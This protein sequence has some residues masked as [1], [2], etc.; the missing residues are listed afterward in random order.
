MSSRGFNTP[1]VVLTQMREYVSR[2]GRPYF[3]GYM[4][5]TKLV[6]LHDPD[7]EITGHEVRRWNLHIEEAPTPDERRVP[8]DAL[9]RSPQLAL[10]APADHAPRKPTGKASDRRA[11]TSLRARGID[12]DAPTNDDPIPF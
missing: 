12:P 2:N 10:S 7:A 8:A 6:L 11:I 5:R 9:S 3:V 4:G 1:R